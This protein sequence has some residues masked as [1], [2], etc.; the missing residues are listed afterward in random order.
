MRGV[1]GFTWKQPRLQRKIEIRCAS[2]LEWR[3]WPYTPTMSVAISRSQIHDAIDDLFHVFE[4]ARE[5]C[6][7]PVIV[8]RLREACHAAEAE[9]WNGLLEILAQW[10]ETEDMFVPCTRF[11]KGFDKRRETFLY[12]CIALADAIGELLNG[13]LS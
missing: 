5:E 7:V 9:I 13:D 1:V 8:A 4:E 12:T 3:P 6:S 10:D 11:A 2:L